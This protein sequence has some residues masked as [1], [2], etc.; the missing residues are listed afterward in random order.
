MDR[1]YRV[2]D[3]CDVLIESRPERQ[4][5]AIAGIAVVLNTGQNISTRHFEV[6]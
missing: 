5:R 6:V 1:V 2:L 4:Y 3:L